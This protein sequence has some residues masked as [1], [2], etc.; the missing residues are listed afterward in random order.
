MGDMNTSTKIG[1]SVVEAGWLLQ[2]PEGQIRGM[3]RRGGLAHVVAGRKIDPASVRE[4]LKGAYAHLLLD[5]VLRGDVKVPRPEYRGGWPAP[6]YPDPIGL[7]LQTGFYFPEDEIEP[8][9]DE[10]ADSLGPELL[11]QPARNQRTQRSL[12]AEFPFALTE[13]LVNICW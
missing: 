10:L 5:V 11:G 3:L 1:L 2:R 7:A 12:N 4:H 13:F 6:L 8:L 9:M